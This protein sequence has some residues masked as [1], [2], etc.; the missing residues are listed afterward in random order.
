MPNPV[1]RTITNWMRPLVSLVSL[2]S[3]RLSSI[4]KVG[5]LHFERWPTEKLID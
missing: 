5:M 3:S 2:P 1:E 4:A